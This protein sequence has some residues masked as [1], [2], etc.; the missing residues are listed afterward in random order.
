MS[1]KYWVY[2]VQKY[3]CPKESDTPIIFVSVKYKKFAGDHLAND[4]YLDSPRIIDMAG[5]TH[6][7]PPI[8]RIP[9]SL[10]D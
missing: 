7:I 10:G 3:G 5:P 1:E 4:E 6:T 9:N 2:D 8:F